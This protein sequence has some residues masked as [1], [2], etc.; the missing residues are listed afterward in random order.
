MSFRYLIGPLFAY[1]QVEMAKLDSWYP[2]TIAK[3]YKWPHFTIQF[4]VATAYF[5]TYISTKTK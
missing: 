1:I 3:C 2:F 5:R 4:R